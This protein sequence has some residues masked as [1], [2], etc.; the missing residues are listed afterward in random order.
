MNTE[1]RIVLKDSA[2]KVLVIAEKGLVRITTTLVDETGTAIPSSAVSA[3]TLT[4]YA[5]NEPN[6]DIINSVNGTDILN[7]GRGTLHATSGLLTVTLT[8]SD[9][10]IINTGNDLEWHRALIQGTFSSKPFKCEIDF[11]VRNLDKV[12]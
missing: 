9:L 12:T 8:G 4:L 1:N 3:L 5:Q 6:Q 11:P 10:T 7:T 2:G